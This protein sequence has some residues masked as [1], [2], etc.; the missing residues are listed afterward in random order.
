MSMVSKAQLKAVQKYEKKAYDKILVR[1][2]KGYLD[3]TLKPA[4]ERAGESV[5]GFVTKAIEERIAREK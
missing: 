1:I 5:N 4:A 3:G 2:P